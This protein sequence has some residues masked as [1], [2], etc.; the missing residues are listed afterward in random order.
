MMS[1][2]NVFVVSPGAKRSVPSAGM[3]S[4]RSEAV[5]LLVA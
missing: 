3:K 1:T 5:P 4:V 2:V